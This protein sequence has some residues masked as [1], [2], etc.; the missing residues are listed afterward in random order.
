VILYIGNERIGG[1]DVFLGN[2][3]SKM[4]TSEAYPSY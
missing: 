4:E 1:N 2:F 3:M